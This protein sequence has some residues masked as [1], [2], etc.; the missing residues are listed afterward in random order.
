MNE[1]IIE[2]S[3]YQEDDQG[4]YNLR[5]RIVAPRKKSPVPTKNYAPPSKNI[6]A[7]TMK[8]VAPPK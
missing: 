3:L 8:M 2:E 5:S 1:Q 6:I 7:S 4:G